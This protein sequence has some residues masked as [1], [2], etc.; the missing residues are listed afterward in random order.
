MCLDTNT[1]RQKLRPYRAST[2]SLGS[3]VSMTPRCPTVRTAAT[4]RRRYLTLPSPASVSPTSRCLALSYHT[5][6]ASWCRRRHATASGLG[7]GLVQHPCARTRKPNFKTTP[8]L[9]LAS[10]GN[11]FCGVPF[12]LLHQNGRVQPNPTF[13]W[14]WRCWSLNCLAKKSWS[15]TTKHGFE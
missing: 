3:I 12:L 11:K 14:K 8:N 9:N 13:F 7:Y 1:T 5:T 10:G 2:V 4:S 15:E 6:V